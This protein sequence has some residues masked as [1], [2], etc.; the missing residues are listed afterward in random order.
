MTQKWHHV[1]D[2][3]V[4]AC[5]N[6]LLYLIP[7]TKEVTYQEHEYNLRIFGSNSSSIQYLKTHLIQ[8]W[9]FIWTNCIWPPESQ[10]ASSKKV[11]ISNWYTYQSHQRCHAI[12][13]LKLIPSWNS[14]SV[15]G[16]S[17]GRVRKEQLLQPD[18]S[19][20]VDLSTV[21]CCFSSFIV[22]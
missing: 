6:N 9:M 14:L 16:S 5:I 15:Q 12:H 19:T 21:S 10:M 13:S 4:T 18:L 20:K 22:L 11:T 8:W 7:L 3:N 17:Q 1:Q 2:K